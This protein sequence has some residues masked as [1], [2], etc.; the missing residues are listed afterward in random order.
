MTEASDSP[1]NTLVAT[2]IAGFDD[3]L[4]GG[5]PTNRIYLIEGNPGSGKTTL[6]LQFLLNGVQN[7][8]RVLYITLSETAEELRAVG[9]SHGWS[10]DVIPIFELIPSEESLDPDAQVMMFHSSEVELG[11]TTRAVLTEV[12][13]L[14]PTRVVFDSLSELRLLAQSQLRYRRQV[15]ALKQFFTGRHCTVLLLDD[16]TA[17]GHDQQLHSIAHG[18]VS[19][20]QLAPEYGAERR[21]LRVLK[22][23]GRQYRGGYHDFRI[24]RGGLAVYPRLVAAEHTRTF[25]NS[26]IPS[27]VASLD[28]LLGGGIERGTSTLLIGPAGVGKSSLTI[29]YAVAAAARGERVS[30]FLFDETIATMIDRSEGLGMPIRAL[31][32]A[33]TVVARQID[34][35]ELSPGEFAHAVRQAAEH[36]GAQ[37]IVI[38]SLNGYL[39]AM[40]EERFLLIQLHE[41]LTYLAQLGVTTMLVVGQHGLVGQ[42]MQTPVDVSYLADTVILLRYFE[43]TGEVRQAISVVKKRNGAHERSI[44]QLTLGSNGITIGEALRSFSGILSGTPRYTGETDTLSGSDQT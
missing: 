16:H 42:A 8:E 18:V 27:G 40:P 36:N 35:A 10:L 20:E 4:A 33:G 37:I 43:A 29:Q 44:R 30:T 25:E 17:T 12:D 3:V 22:L 34:P 5:L 38:D 19:M 14:R 6:A 11:E 31:L 13:R 23:R 26:L 7:G 1:T 32:D 2:G 28:M 15:L 24:I 21:R 41:L 9:V 39:N